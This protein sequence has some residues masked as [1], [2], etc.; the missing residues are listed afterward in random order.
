MEKFR[1]I[2]IIFLLA[3]CVLTSSAQGKSASA[4]LQEGL[5]A[6]EIE[7]DMDKAISIYEQVIEKKT[8]RDSHKAQ[9]LYRLGMCYLKTQNQQR[10]KAMFEKLVTEYPEQKTVI[11][12][13]RPMLEEMSYSDPA[14]LMP[15]DTK[16]YIELGSP[17]RQIETILKMLQGT[18]L[19]NPLAMLG[20]TRADGESAP[21]IL[22]ALLNPSMMTEFKKVRGTAIGITDIRSNNPPGIMVLYPGKS[23]ALRGLI[24]AGLGMVAKPGEPIEGMQSMVVG[25]NAGVIYDDN[26][27]IIAQPIEQLRWC[28]KQYKGT[29]KEPTLASQNGAFAKLNRKTR[30]QSALTIWLDID[31]TF[32]DIKKQFGDN[33]LPQ[34]IRA[35]DLF[36]DLESID[37]LIAHLSIEASGITIDA[38]VRFKDGHNCLV[39]DIIRTPNLSRDGFKAVPSET[40]ALVSLALGE[41][42]SVG[43]QKARQAIENITGLD[44]GREIFANIEQVT[45]FAVPPGEASNENTLAKS[46]S[47]AVGCV[48]LVVTSHN[49]Q[50]TRQLLTKLLI[51]ADTITNM[52]MDEQPTAQE[53]STLVKYN[54][55]IFN[56][57]AAYCYLGQEGKSTV[58]ALSPEVI[59]ASLSAIKNR[60]SV[61]TGG[62]LQKFFRPLSA[63]V[64]KM[65]L[66]NVGGAIRMADAHIHK[67]VIATEKPEN[68]PLSQML[69]QLAQ[70][71]DKTSLQFRTNENVNNFGL[72]LSTSE[73][74]PIG[75]VLPLLMQ[76]PHS[77]PRNLVIK[78]VN[79]QPT[80]G[81]MVGAKTELDWVAGINARGHKIY[82][83]TNADD[84]SLLAEVTR[85]GYAELPDLEEGTTYYWR[86]DEVQADGSVITGDVWS[87]SRGKLV[88]WW[89]L[90]EAEGSNASDSSGNNNDG[91]VVGASW[92]PNSGIIEG[93]VSFNNVDLT[94]RVEVPITGMTASAGTVSIWCNFPG[95]RPG[96]RYFFGHTSNPAAAY[97]DKIQLFMDKND[98]Q[99]DLGFGDRHFKKTNITSLSINTWHHIVLTWNAGRYA[100]YVD[101]D[102]KA[103][104]SYS[105]FDSLGSVAHIGNDGRD[106]PDD[107]AFFGLLDEVRI[108]NYALSQIE[109]EAL[110]DI[111]P[112]AT[113]PSPSNGSSVSA[114]KKLKLSWQPGVSAVKHKVYFG[115]KSDELL[116]VGEVTDLSYDELPKLEKSTTYYWRIDEVQADGSVTIGDVWSFSRGKLVGWW[117]LDE[118]EGRKVSD[119]SGNNNDGTLV[120]ASWAP[121]SGKIEGAVSFNNVDLNN[122]VEVPITGMTASTGTV[123]VWG[124][125]PGTRPGIR[126]FFGHTSIPAPSFSDRI[127]LFMD[128]NDNQLDL[129]IGGDHFKKTNITS[130][131]INTWHHIV[132][133][134]NSG[135]Y[136]VYV[137]ADKKAAGSYSGFDSLGSVA[138]IGNDGRDPPNYGAF[139]GLLDDVRIYNYALSAD[140]I[141]ELCKTAQLS[142]TN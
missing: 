46:I 39:Y 22:S 132:L 43:G 8:A 79:P 44:V 10:A 129:G 73:L 118:A 57:Q 110:Y 140:E 134:W 19:A 35:A 142:S 47:P 71:C 13:V 101:A 74:P 62:P 108:Y 75:T 51:L 29:S 42:E 94:D 67:E 12:K 49:P 80:N 122:Y 128:K 85:P 59:N 126:Y 45:L 68:L 33:K 64:S 82:F 93:A 63:D 26:V 4:L 48:G 111:L 54:F 109:I 40:F 123:S 9:A 87:F 121:N 97:S 92:V 96:I 100:V 16:M 105:G 21:D 114:A 115:T 113:R 88:G 120:G 81:A 53:D 15:P 56:N 119:S 84:L 106:S 116:P 25:G 90:D 55:G 133:T 50:K 18:P 130:L 31:Q 112:N 11:E 58:L 117:K 36:A 89:K 5:Y 125:F 99:L 20:G 28:A 135:H 17:G 37:D 27:I 30:E 138:H 107:G 38:N 76:L 141:K 95:T 77:V 91:T 103:A 24:F 6:E 83:G 61:L 78:A 60:Q 127:Q 1:N 131:S 137:D 3:V 41:P 14:A 136:A 86:I 98:N 2:T 7:G 23:D 72:E 124:N 102:K 69:G 32:E 139:F 65:A 66:V 104:G 70:A 52:Q 34:E